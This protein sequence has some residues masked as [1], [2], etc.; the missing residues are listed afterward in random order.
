MKVREI[1]VADL[2]HKI[3]I[4]NDFVNKLQYNQTVDHMNMDTTDTVVTYHFTL[5]CVDDDNGEFDDLVSIICRILLTRRFEVYDKQEVNPRLGGVWLDV[6]RRKFAS[7]VKR[8]QPF[9]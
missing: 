9:L 5:V 7:L 6:C 2:L 1:S 4:F 3:V 8:L